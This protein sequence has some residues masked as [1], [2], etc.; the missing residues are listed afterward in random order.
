MVNDESEQVKFQN[1]EEKEFWKSI[2]IEATTIESANSE[3]VSNYADAMLE[4]F[5]KRVKEPV[6]TWHS[7]LTK[8]CNILVTEDGDYCKECLQNEI[9]ATKGCL[10]SRIAN[11]VL[12]SYCYSSEV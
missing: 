3:C 5:R 8:G 12:C 10:N 1:D 11:T 4:E 2:A 9:C 6:E 7:C